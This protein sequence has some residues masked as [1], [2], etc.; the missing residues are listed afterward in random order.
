MCNKNTHKHTNES[1][2][3]PPPKKQNKTKWKQNKKNP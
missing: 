1:Y 3:K 2:I